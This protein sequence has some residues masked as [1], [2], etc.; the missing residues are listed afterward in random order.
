MNHLILTVVVLGRRFDLRDGARIMGVHSLNDS[1]RT[2]YVPEGVHG[3]FQNQIWSS[4]V[5]A[6][7]VHRVVLVERV[8]F[9]IYAL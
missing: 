2:R 3:G 1:M 8:H 5:G 9:T 6:V 4:D 7:R